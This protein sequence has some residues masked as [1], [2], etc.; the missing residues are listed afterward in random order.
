M[1]IGLMLFI[2][3]VFLYYAY[4]T[5]FKE[6]FEVKKVYNTL[7]KVLDTR[8]ILL[9]KLSNEKVNKKDMAKVIMLIDERKKTKN[10]GYSIRMDADVKL[11][12]E[13]KSF[14]PKLEQSLDNPISKNK[15][16]KL[17]IHIIVQ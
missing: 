10:A 14:Y 13:L 9:L 1:W 17:E 12:H 2:V 4:G 5:Y 11:N 7:Q 6:Y 16:R 3:A 8:D 15:Q